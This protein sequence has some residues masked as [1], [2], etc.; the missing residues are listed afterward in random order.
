[1]KQLLSTILLAFIAGAV[2]TNCSKDDDPVPYTGDYVSLLSLHTFAVP[3]GDTV[4]IFGDT[5]TNDTVLGDYK[6]TQVQK[7][8]LQS[9]IYQ[10]NR[11]SIFSPEYHVAR[12]VAEKAVHITGTSIAED[13]KENKLFEN[14]SLV[15]DLEYTNGDTLQTP[16]CTTITIQNG[17][18]IKGTSY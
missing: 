14:V 18:Q 15:M 17:E 12:N 7:D 1:M 5:I 3:E 4:F 9:Y 10:W 2:F 16:I 13:L 8:S 6:L 11:K